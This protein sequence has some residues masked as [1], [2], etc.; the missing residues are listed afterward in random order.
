MLPL[1]EEINH[2]TEEAD[3]ADE[4]DWTLD[5]IHSIQQKIH[6]LATNYRKGPPFYTV[7]LLVNN[8]P[9]K[10]I[11]D[12]GSPV[13]LIPKSK[14]NKETTLKPITVD[15]W[16]VNDNKMKYEEKTTA[17]IGRYKESTGTFDNNQ[18]THT[19]LS[20]D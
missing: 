17:N 11:I 13:T 3:S 2:I 10:F 5:R 14:F 19:L 6:S 12:T 8:R 18:N 7:T 16:D 20:L 15:Y 1:N 9:I 4:D